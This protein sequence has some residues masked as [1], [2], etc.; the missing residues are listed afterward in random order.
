MEIIAETK[1]SATGKCVAC[2]AAGAVCFAILMTF[3]V[4]YFTGQTEL[5]AI[6]AAGPLLL[7]VG[8][9]LAVAGITTLRKLRNQPRQ[10]VREGDKIDFGNGLICTADKI[11]NVNYDVY[12]S[13]E[14]LIV[15]VGGNMLVYEYV[16]DVRRA[17]DRLIELKLQSAKK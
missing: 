5:A 13:N 9:G 3:V 15:Q 10:I 7:V 1:K 16:A 8:G 17:Y 11:E 14:R 2:I 6:V 4:Q 12:K